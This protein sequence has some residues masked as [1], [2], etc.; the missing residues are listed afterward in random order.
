LDIAIKNIKKLI[1]SHKTLF[2]KF[3]KDEVIGVAFSK[4]KPEKRD[5]FADIGC[6]SCK[7]S[8]FFSPYV[9]KV[10]AV[11]LS[12][13]NIKPEYVKDNVEL[14]EM[15]GVEFLKNYRADIIFFGGTKDIEKMLRLAFDRGTK[16]C[17]VSAARI[18]VAIKAKKTMEELGVFKEIV[19]VC[20]WKSYKLAGYTAFKP[21][22]PVFLVVGVSS[23]SME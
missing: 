20:V 22:N 16:K 10:Y 3:T 4:L 17:C 13:E 12:L 2:V 11:D 9:K 21:I 19:A 14:L 6:Y 18:E 5:V 7:V 15:N 23:C 1:I 8:A